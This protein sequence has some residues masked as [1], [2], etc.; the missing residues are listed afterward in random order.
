MENRF[1]NPDPGFWIPS[2]S[3]SETLM[4]YQDGAISGP[5]VSTVGVYVCGCD[6][7]IG[8]LNSLNIRPNLFHSLARSHANWISSTASISSHPVFLSNDQISS[9]VRL[10]Q[11]SFHPIYFSCSLHKLSP[12]FCLLIV[13]T[14]MH[15]SIRHAV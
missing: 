9:I 1:P 3:G 2:G 5:C 15:C 4:Y 14:Y 13:T 11:I 12:F 7:D 6:F 8:K 10:G